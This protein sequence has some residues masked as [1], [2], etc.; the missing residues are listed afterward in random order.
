MLTRGT[1]DEVHTYCKTMIDDM[2]DGVI[3][4]WGCGIPDNATVEIVRTMISAATGD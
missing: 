2:G 3:P 4:S 1:P